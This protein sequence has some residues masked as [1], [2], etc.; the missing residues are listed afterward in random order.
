MQLSGKNFRLSASD[1][2]GHINCQ[3][4]TQLDLKVARGTLPKPSYYYDP[5]LEVLVERGRRHEQG[6]LEHLRAS[7]REVTTISGVG[8][9]ATAVAETIAAMKQGADVIA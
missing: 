1:L 5:A 2:I 3:F 8:V 6:Y 9:D 4:L 7:G